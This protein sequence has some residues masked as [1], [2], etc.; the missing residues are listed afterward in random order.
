MTKMMRFKH[1]ALMSFAE[2]WAFKKSAINLKVRTI[3][4][5]HDNDFGF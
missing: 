2:K 1:Q 4:A 5:F 3:N